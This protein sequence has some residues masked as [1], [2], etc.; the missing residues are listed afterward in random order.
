MD[1]FVKIKKKKSSHTSF[2]MNV[3]A[4]FEKKSFSGKKKK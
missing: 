1:G 4:Q 2:Y 3:Y